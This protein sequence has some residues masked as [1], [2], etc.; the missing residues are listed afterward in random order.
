[1]LDADAEPAFDRCCK[2]D[3]SHQKEVLLPAHNELSRGR[4]SGRPA[5][6]GAG[7]EALA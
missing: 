5:H 2:G 4:V 6:D 3:P 1:M 7:H